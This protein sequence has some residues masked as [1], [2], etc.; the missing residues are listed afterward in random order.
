MPLQYQPILEEDG[1]EDEDL[2]REELEYDR[3]YFGENARNDENDEST[4]VFKYLND[5]LQRTE[6]YEEIDVSVQARRVD[7]LIML[8]MFA[9]THSL[10][11]AAL[12]DLFKLINSIFI[13]PILPQS[14]YFLDK[15]FNPDG[16][17]T[18]HLLCNQCRSYIG[19]YKKKVDQVFN[20]T[21]C[22]N[23]VH[24]NKLKNTDFFITLNIS[25]AIKNLLERHWT[26]YSRIMNRLSEENVYTDFYDGKLYM[27][28]VQTLEP[29]I[30]RLFVTLCFNADGAVVFKKAGH[31]MWLLQ[32][33]LNELP[34]NTKLSTPITFGIWFGDSKPNM[35][36][37]LK[38][39]VA[40]MNELART[41]V[42]CH[43][44]GEEKVVK[45]FA[46]CCCVDS[47][48]RAPIQGIS[49][50]NGN[51]GCSW[52][53]HPG[54]SVKINDKPDCKT[55]YMKYP[56]RN[57]RPQD[58][59]H[60]AAIRDMMIGTERN[61]RDK[62]LT[63]HGF[64]QSSQLILLDKFN[65]VS[66]FVPDYMH[67][68]PLG[69]ARQ[70]TNFWFAGT[71]E[72]CSLKIHEKEIDDILFT[73]TPPR[74]VA[75]LSRPISQRTH[76]NA[77]EYENW[78][79]FH[80][81]LIIKKYFTQQ[82][83]VGHWLKFVEGLYILL[84]HRV[85]DDEINVAHNLLE[86][87]VE[88]TERLYGI[89][90]MSY[91]VHQNLHLAPSCRD[92]G[93]AWS[94]SSY[95]FENGNG[96]ILKKIHAANGVHEQ[97]RRSV[98]MDLAFNNLLAKIPE[99]DNIGLR[100]CEEISQRKTIKT[101]KISQPRYFG[102]ERSTAAHLIDEFNLS[103]NAVSYKRLVK[104]SCVYTSCDSR[105]ERSNNSIVL[106]NDGR[107]AEIQDFVLDEATG[108]ELTTVKV[109]ETDGAFGNLCNFYRKVTLI[110]N[111]IEVVET[112]SIFKPCVLQP[113]NNGMRL[114]CAVPNIWHY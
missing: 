107:Y 40:Q 63:C 103:A 14:R 30:R 60:D 35:N 32:I 65:I 74:Q 78:I 28:F 44:A 114:I 75:R 12:V 72:G 80:S 50:W 69:V 85:T 26:E 6:N 105:C 37:F 89:R 98:V 94:H 2:I 57:P 10:S 8:L 56:V 82:E 7:L 92:Y 17:A 84:K 15:L 104:D 20:C 36:V 51:F 27:E 99:D 3:R 31:S 102:I 68:G 108:R 19:T 9:S 106:L 67:L 91:N 101:A 77:R 111:D 62:T 23:L 110:R 49:Q 83:Y 66:G 112:S 58:R 45:V 34:V 42:K 76:W 55:T 21:S 18:Y 16:A 87:F 100:Y 97:I 52:C 29:A 71:K 48:A 43:V 88:D 24:V 13:Q 79:L 81:P 38:P 54:V 90:M 113:E 22:D 70:F 46:L 93:L 59:T 41:G 33:M 96:M 109:I 4:D 86:S 11:L 25:L 47:A 53:L 95:S 61:R 64:K 1:M 5:F 73:L 39:F